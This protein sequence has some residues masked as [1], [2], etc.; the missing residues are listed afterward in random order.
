MRTLSPAGEAL[1]A[2]LQAGE[3][4]PMVQ[5]VEMALSTTLRLTTAGRALQ[6]AGETWEPSGLGTIEPIKNGVG[7]VEGLAFSMPGI[8]QTQLALVLAEPVEGRRVR[9][10]D[11]L[12][13][14]DTG[15]VG[16]AMLAWVGTLNVP[17]IADGPEAVVSVTAEHRGMSALRRKPRRYTAQEQQRLYP[18]DTSLAFDPATDAAPLQ[19]PTASFFRK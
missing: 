1:L 18:G 9:V 7:E 19:W 6:W 13:D 10:W 5:F 15:V 11:A 2:R 12:I 8:D 17:S 14:P 3:R 4:I 16:D